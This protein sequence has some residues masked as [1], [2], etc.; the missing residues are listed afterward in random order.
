MGVKAI[1][2]EYAGYRFRSR[3]EARWAVFFDALGIEWEYEPQGYTLKDGTNYLPDFYIH[4]VGGRTGK[5]KRKRGDGIF[6]EVKGFL[7]GEDRNKLD[8]FPYAIYCV[9]DIPTKKDPEQ[10]MWDKC[11]DSNYYLFS[12]WNIDKDSYSVFFCK[13]NGEICIYG[14]DNIASMENVDLKS[15]HKAYDKARKARFEYGECG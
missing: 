5:G 15:I 10:Y 9:G 14:I 1:E 7:K 3:L 6:V 4:K 13:V 8:K 2:T 11:E 12:S